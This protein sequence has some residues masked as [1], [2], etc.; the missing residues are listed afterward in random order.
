M[1]DFMFYIVM[2]LILMSIICLYF[3]LANA[4]MDGIDRL[5][6]AGGDTP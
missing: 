5:I 3:A 1:S 6:S 4:I 2:A